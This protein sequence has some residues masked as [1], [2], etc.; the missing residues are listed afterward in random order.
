M[1]EVISSLISAFLFNL[2]LGFKTS[3]N[4]VY[5]LQNK[6]ECAESIKIICF[7]SKYNVVKFLHGYQMLFDELKVGNIRT[8]WQ[9][10]TLYL[11]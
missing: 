1:Y 2:Y 11:I 10:F 5:L 9:Y 8:L 7:G 4:R 3:L 6:G